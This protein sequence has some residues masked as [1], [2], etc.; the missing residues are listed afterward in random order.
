MDGL[1]QAHI[2]VLIDHGFDGSDH[3]FFLPLKVYRKL[4]MHG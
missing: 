3:R 1:S 2:P 4:A